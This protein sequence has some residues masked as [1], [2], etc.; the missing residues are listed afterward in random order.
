MKRSSTV[1][2][3]ACNISSARGNDAGALQ[4]FALIQCY[5]IHAN[6]SKDLS[7]S[8]LRIALHSTAGNP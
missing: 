2:A 5:A 1:C 6:V 8:V 4:Y 3:S 7:T